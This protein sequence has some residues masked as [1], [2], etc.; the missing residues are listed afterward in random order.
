MKFSEN[1]KIIAIDDP[2]SG[3]DGPPKIAV[4]DD[5]KVILRHI[6]YSN[7]AVITKSRGPN[8]NMGNINEHGVLNLYVVNARTG[9][10][11]FNHF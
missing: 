5:I 1:E 10:V 2:Y 3:A 6:D 7:F 8:K 4:Y 9:R 11:L